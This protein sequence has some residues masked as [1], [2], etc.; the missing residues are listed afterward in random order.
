MTTITAVRRGH[1]LPRGWWGLLLALLL[2]LAGCSDD[3]AQA[4]SVTTQPATPP[5][6][7]DGGSATFSVVAEG[8]NLR[9]QWQRNRV[10]VPGANEARYTLAPVSYAD[11]GSRWRVAI[12]GDGGTTESDEVTLTVLPVAPAITAAPAAA[13]VNDGAGASFSVT[14]T[15][16]APLSYQWQRNGSDIAGATAAS[17]TLTVATLADAG[18]TFAVRVSNPGGSIT[19]AAAALS[20]APVA[21]TITAPPAAQAVTAGQGAS[22]SVAAT[23]SAPLAYQWQRNGSDIAGATEASYTLAGTTLADD[24]AVFSVRVS[25]AAGSVGSPGVVLGVGAPPPPP[26]ITTAPQAA[27]V[28]EGQAATFTVLASGAAPL[29]YQWQRNG[30]A[31]AGATAASYTT[32]ATTR[33]DNG[34]RFS[35][36]VSNGQGSVASGEA[37]L[38]VDAAVQASGRA[39][40]AFGSNH[41]VAVRGDGSVIA[42]GSNASGQ[43]GSGATIAGSNARLVATTAVAVAA[44]STE[45]IALGGDGIVRGW[46]RKFSNITIIGGDAAVSGTELATPATGGWPGGITHIVTGTGNAFALGLRSDGSVVQMPGVA[47]T[48]TGG[49]NQTARAVAGL[50]PIVA[51]GA[52]VQGNPSAIAA[53]GSVWRIAI[54][55]IGG[56]NWQAT[57]SPVAGLA[58]AVAA[59]CNGV[60]CIALDTAGAVHTFPASGS[61]AAAAVTGLPRTV[62]IAATGTGFLAVAGDGTLWRWNQG[63]TPTAVAG[64]AGVLEAAGGSGTV[65]VRLADGSVWGYGSNSFGELG[66]GT[67]PTT[68]PVPVPGIRLD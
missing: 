4:P 38:T 44:G 31:I 33:A 62:Q 18:A 24:G 6:V 49:L 3:P 39:R 9:Y 13:A 65:L 28:A 10:N 40:I 16:S 22:F 29:A 53:D 56:G 15:G 52:G 11:N 23:G 35:V 59:V 14:A 54:T 61:G 20:V 30:S 60:G 21:P 50:P 32:P 26:Q 55:A 12:T 37:T 17:Y 47:T 27:R 58:G 66:S 5:A 36:V 45:S 25:N 2:A 7:A 34:A 42:W 67:A 19:S 48:I 64:L 68:T 46:G 43:L 1:G 63:A 8:S 51:L 57:V 41:V